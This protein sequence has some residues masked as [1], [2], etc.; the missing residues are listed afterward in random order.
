MCRLKEKLV[1]AG[2]EDKIELNEIFG[3]YKELFGTEKPLGLKEFYTVLKIAFPQPKHVENA[4]A[5][6]QIDTLILQN[7]KYAPL[8]SPD[9]KVFSFCFLFQRRKK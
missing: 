7:V 4:V 2:L 9:G 5:N 1:K 8:R 6:G 3:L